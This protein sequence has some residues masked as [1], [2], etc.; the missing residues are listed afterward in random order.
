[1]QLPKMSEG[2][3]RSA[4]AIAVSVIVV[5]AVVWMLVG[6]VAGILVG[7]CDASGGNGSRLGNTAATR[8][9]NSIQSN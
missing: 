7:S 9:C 6:I 5:G 2:A 3:W 1:M 8:S 4:A